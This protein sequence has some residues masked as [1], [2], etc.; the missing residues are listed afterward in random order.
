MNAVYINA[1]GGPEELVYGVLPDPVPGARE[2]LIKV[3]AAAVNPVDWKV[4]EGR[5]KFLSGKN[6]PIVMGTEVSGTVVAIGEKVEGFKPGERVYAGLSHRGGG[7]AALVAVDYRK[8]VR[9]P[10]ALPFNEAS[11]LAVAGVT[12]MQAF[13]LHYPVKPGDEVLVNGGS[14]GVGTYAVQ[15]AKVL[16][17]RVTA[18]CSSRNVSLVRSLGADDVIDYEREDFRSRDAAFHVVLDAASNAF[19]PETK[20]CLKKGGM[21]VKLNLSAGSLF[22]SLWSRFF[23]SKKLKMIL[24]KNRPED[25]RWLIEQVISGKIQVVIDRTFSLG[26]ARIAHEYSQTGRARGKVVLEV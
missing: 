3:A 15:I 20:R 25:V 10:D 2:I 16:G 7:Y 9:I 23:S 12:P 22:L 8:A 6:F 18:V 14:G 5:L 17:A 26:D 13:T 1:Y 11:T 21:L 4:R 24:V 19:F